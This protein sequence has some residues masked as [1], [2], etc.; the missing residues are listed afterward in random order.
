MNAFTPCT[1]NKPIKKYVNRL[2]N[3][4]N[5]IAVPPRP[6]RSSRYLSAVKVQ[7]QDSAKVPD[8]GEQIAVSITQSNES[9][10]QKEKRKVRISRIDQPQPGKV[11]EK[12]DSGNQNGL[13]R[14]AMISD[15]SV[16]LGRRSSELKTGDLTIA[17]DL[18][19]QLIE[20]LVD[21]GACVSA[22]DEH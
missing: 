16:S 9:Q 22:M 5:D 19:G 12:Q 10:E 4:R 11:P 13:Y 3:Q 20:L 7:P 6:V 15:I 17:W 1:E 8:T 14:R 21:T 2:N 18:E